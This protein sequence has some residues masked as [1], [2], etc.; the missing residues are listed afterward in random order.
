MPPPGGGKEEIRA[1]LLRPY[2][3]R[4]RAERG[5]SACRS[6]VAT[7][8][9]TE[10]VLDDDSAW[11]SVGAAT[12]TL[13][14]LDTALGE[15][16]IAKRGEWATHPKALGAYVRMLRVAS[17]LPDAYQYLCAHA[18]EVTRAGSFTLDHAGRTQV[19]ISDRPRE[20]GGDE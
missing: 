9:L 17:S 16:S 19:S 6:L 2:F 20:D 18:S 10:H 11:L 8:G 14:A 7:L 5:D 13:A 1:T 15:S 12:R 3:L 4:L